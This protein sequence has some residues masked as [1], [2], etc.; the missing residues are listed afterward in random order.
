MERKQEPRIASEQS[1]VVGV[2]S[3]SRFRFTGV[4]V[5]AK[6]VG[7]ADQEDSGTPCDLELSRLFVSVTLLVLWKKETNVDCAAQLCSSG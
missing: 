7:E 1:Q 5:G 6:T 2:G 3:D 4:T